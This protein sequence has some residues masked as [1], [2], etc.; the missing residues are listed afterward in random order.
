MAVLDALGAR[1]TRTLIRDLVEGQYSHPVRVV[2]FNTAEG[3]ARDLTMN[4]VDEL[5]RRYAEFG[6]VPGPILDFMEANR[7]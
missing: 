1:P 2:A 6:E 3:W 4:V 5:R 7:R